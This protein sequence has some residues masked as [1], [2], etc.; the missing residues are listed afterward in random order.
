MEDGRWKMK[1]LYSRWLLRVAVP[2]VLCVGCMRDAEA[3][4]L[5]KVLFEEF[6]GEW[7]SLCPGG[8]LEMEKV[9]RANAGRVVPI[10]YH[11]NDPLEPAQL[12]AMLD[13]IPFDPLYPGG[14]FDRLPW[15]ENNPKHKMS[16]D[17]FDFL[18][19]FEKSAARPAEADISAAVSLDRTSRLLTVNTRVEFVAAMQGDFR[20]H[21]VV[22]ENGVQRNGTQ[23]NAYD[24]D[25][26]SY[27][28]LFGAGNPLR[29][30]AHE[31]VARS[32]LG[33][34]AGWAGA[35]PRGTVPG[36]P[37][38]ETFL[39]DVPA[40][41]SIDKLGVAVFVSKYQNRSLNGNEV[42]N[43]EGYLGSVITDVP[44]APVSAAAWSLYPNPCNGIAYLRAKDS[45]AGTEAVQIFDIMG[46][47]MRDARVNAFPDGRQLD[48]RALPSGLY[49]VRFSAGTS[50]ETMLLMKR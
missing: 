38:F 3:Q 9:L 24:N 28:S 4:P 12:N 39:Y 10:S 5:R 17:R 27:P 6:T 36:R 1:R 32:L 30:W 33:G 35:I 29:I 8:T 45:D 25:S 31:Y 21:C 47:R 23:L 40:S 37:Y 42:L 2:V 49:H 16:V 50:V 11:D 14:T 20:M 13:S 43:A 34:A 26:L 41:T 44:A 18:S 7:C 15:S 19:T 22:T 48:L 46:R